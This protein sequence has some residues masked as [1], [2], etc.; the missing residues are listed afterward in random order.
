MAMLEHNIGITDP[1]R[2]HPHPDIRMQVLVNS[3][4]PQWKKVI[5]DRG[6]FIELTREARREMKDIVGLAILPN[7]PSRSDE[8][9]RNSFTDT[10]L[11][12]WESLHGRAED[13]NALTQERLAK[14]RTDLEK[15]S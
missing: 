3:I 15:E 6:Q 5:P 13:L 2:T 1:Q 10:V 14:K 7:P 9:Y 12:L 8:A 4:W 11:D